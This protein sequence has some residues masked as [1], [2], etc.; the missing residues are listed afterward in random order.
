MTHFHFPFPDGIAKRGLAVISA[1]AALVF[2]ADA[3]AAETHLTPPEY[4]TQAK[5]ILKKSIGF[6]TVEGFGNTYAY[7]E[8]LAGVLK[9]AGYADKDIEVTKMGDTATLV[10]WL[11][12]DSAEKPL[13]LSGHMDV[14]AADPKDW[15]RDPFTAVEENGF[16]YG[17]GASDMKFGVS[18][19][20]T[21]MARL[22]REGFKPKRDVILV[23]SGDEETAMATTAKLAERFK[24]AGLLL[25]ADGASGA[26]THDNQPIAYYVQGAEKTYADFKIEFTNPGGHSSEP[27][28]DNAIYDLAR[29]LDKIAAYKFPVESSEITRESFREAAKHESGEVAKAMLDFADN[30]KDK[31]AIKTLRAHPEYVGQLGTTCVATMLKGGHALNALPQSAIADVNCRIWPGVKVESVRQTLAKVIDDPKASVTLI[32]ESSTPEAPASPMRADVMAAVRKAVDRRYPGLPIV[33]YMSAGASDSLYFRYH[34]V[35]SY[36]A[37]GLFMRAEDEFAHGLNE[38]SPVD[39]IDGALD[40]WHVMI[41]TLAG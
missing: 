34:G 14:V 11:R 29:A 10:A 35:D 32:E 9:D 36:G 38:R 16:I 3:F 4:V 26:L 27:R 19:L 33:P 25:N 12:G 13:L 7:A 8:Y 37:S 24:D 28:A 40:H 21:T 18:M 30:P 41:T 5:D 22:K 2:A 23:L 17:R 1:A 20:V 31:K 15:E 39:Q 6:K